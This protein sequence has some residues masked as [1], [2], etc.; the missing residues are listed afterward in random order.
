MGITQGSAVSQTCIT[1]HGWSRVILYDAP[2]T[3]K[4]DLLKLHKL[5]NCQICT[6]LH[7]IVNPVIRLEF[8]LNALTYWFWKLHISNLGNTKVLK[9]SLLQHCY[10]SSHSLYIP[11][12]C[13]KTKEGNWLNFC[14]INLGKIH[15]ILKNILYLSLPSNYKKLFQETINHCSLLFLEYIYHL[16]IIL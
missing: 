12:M 10:L 3:V 14:Y 2:I 6:V 13:W 4:H 15:I 11:W 7:K 8:Y 1:K 5:R 9:N 16:T